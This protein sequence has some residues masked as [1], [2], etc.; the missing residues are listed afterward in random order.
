MFMGAGNSLIFSALEG[1]AKIYSPLLKM[2]VTVITLKGGFKGGEIVPSFAIGATFGCL[3]GHLFG[4]SPSM[5]AAIC[6][7]AFFS[8]VTNCP[9]TALILGFELFGFNGALFFI[10]ATVIAVY[11]SGFYSLYSS[12]L[13]AFSAYEI[14]EKEHIHKV[15]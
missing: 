15:H 10:L 12:Q 6:M 4:L 2:I 5:C 7:V 14:D 1:N 3:M 11:A 9:I 13:V 8:A